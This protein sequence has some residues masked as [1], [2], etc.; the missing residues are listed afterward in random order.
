MQAP[1]CPMPQPYLVPVRFSVSR[2]TQRRG[3]SGGTSTVTDRPFTTSVWGIAP[4][5][6]GRLNYGRAGGRVKRVSSW[7]DD[8]AVSGQRA[9]GVGA[10]LRDLHNFH[11]ER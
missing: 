3:V 10:S 9:L 2:R 6:R 7:L 1:H 5:G 11:A 4:F 8:E